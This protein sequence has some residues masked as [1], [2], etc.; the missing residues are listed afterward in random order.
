MKYVKFVSIVFCALLAFSAQANALLITPSETAALT[1][2]E[3]SQA[4]INAIILPYIAPATELYKS[5]VDGGKEEG[6]LAGSYKTTYFNTP[7]DPSDALIEYVGG[8]YVGPIA[9]L[10][11][12]DGKQ[13]PAWYLFNLTGLLWNGTDDIKL[14]NFWPAQGAISHVSLYGGS[15][16]VPEPA[17]M[18]LLGLGLVGLAGCS[19]RKF[20]NN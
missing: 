16:S 14:E 11:V 13:D 20:K 15:V 9:W 4:A 18:L 19:R 12:K 5:E 1:G 2:P 17:T 7:S 3:T 6:F 8:P 10:L